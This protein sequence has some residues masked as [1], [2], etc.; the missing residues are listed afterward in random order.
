MQQAIDAVIEL[1]DG[2]R[3]DLS[4]VALD[5]EGLG[6]FER[7]AY[8]AARSIPP[9]STTTYGAIAAAL[10]EP[11]AARAVGQAMGHNPFPVIVPCH[12][13]LATD[14]SLGGFSAG[15]GTRTKLRLLA[16]EGAE[17]AKQVDLFDG[18]AG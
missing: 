18:P 8:E 2:A 10:G 4:F 12:R 6:A 14:G 7:R 9:G 1:L 16:I 5:C 3:T 17:A 15:G 11:G 13:V